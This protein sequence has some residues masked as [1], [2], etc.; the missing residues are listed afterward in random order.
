MLNSGFGGRRA[1]FDAAVVNQE[2]QISQGN[3]ADI[4]SDAVTRELPW[5]RWG[6]ELF[7]AGHIDAPFETYQD[8]LEYYGYEDL[9]NGMWRK[10]EP[11]AESDFPVGTFESSSA[12]IQ[13]FAP[14]PG[15]GQNRGALGL[16]NWRV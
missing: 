12:P 6:Q 7:E 3:F 11:A 15:F 5:E 1:Q 2:L 9:G 10:L 8:F 16:V 4:V 13:Q 14:F